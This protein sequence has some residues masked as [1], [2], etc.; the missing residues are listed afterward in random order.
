MLE[1]LWAFVVICVIVLI[2]AKGLRFRTVVIYEYQRGL[3]YRKGRFQKLLG[4]GQ[5]WIWPPSTA[6]VPIDVRPVLVTVP[7]QEVISADGVTVKITLVAQFEVADPDLAINKNANYQQAFYLLMQMAVRQLIGAEKVE[8]IIEQ[9]ISLNERIVELS[10]DKIAALG[11]R[12]I[13]AEVKDVMLPG[14][15]RKTFA[16]IVKAQ[17]DGQA[18]LERARGETAALRSLANAAKMAEGN[19]NL[20]QL[21]ALQLMSESTGN[22]IML[23]VPAGS[24]PGPASKNGG[25]APSETSSTK[26]ES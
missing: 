2:T 12:L 10:K 13:S 22:T 9:R 7:S 20:L 1:A 24:P 23:G 14:E 6:I 17:K 3:K 19:P 8:S 21:R 5:Y 11:L 4:A 15:L 26:E 16:Q 18:A 25:S